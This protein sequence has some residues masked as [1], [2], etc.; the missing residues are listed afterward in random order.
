MSGLELLEDT[1]SLE[2]FIAQLATRLARPARRGRARIGFS[3]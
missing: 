1:N 2:R 3:G